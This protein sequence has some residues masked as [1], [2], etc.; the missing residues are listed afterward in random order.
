MPED[1]TTPLL[2]ICIP[3]YKGAHYLKVTLEAVLPQAA[4]LGHSVEVVVSKISRS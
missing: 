3:T 2:S 4:Q 1:G